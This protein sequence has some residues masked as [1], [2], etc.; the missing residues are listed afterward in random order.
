MA[1]SKRTSGNSS[2]FGGGL[3]SPDA[4]AFFDGEGRV[5][6]ANEAARSEG[7]PKPEIG[8]SPPS[9]AVPFW[10]DEDGRG[11]LLRAA[12]AYV[13]NMEVRFISHWDHKERV[14][15]VSVRRTPGGI[16]AAAR[17][18]TQKLS[19]HE[20]YKMLYEELASGS[21][22][23]LTTGFLNRERF[24][25]QLTKEIEKGSVALLLFDFD[26][27]KTLNDT[28]GSEAGDEY[29]S[30]VGE[31]IRKTFAAGE[32]FG[33]VGGDEI[34]IAIPGATLARATE[35]AD[36]LVSLI[37]DLSP[38]YHGH[39]LHLSASLGVALY[40]DHAPGP[41]ELFQAADFA[42][43][44][45]RRRG[46]ARFKIH[47]P[48]DPEKNRIHILRG[49]ANRVREALENKRFVPVFQ[50]VA[51]VLSGKIVSVE[52]LVRL[53][54]ADGT[55]TSPAEFLDAAER[56]GLVTL[57][58]RVVIAAAFDALAGFQR[59]NP[60]LEM[61][62][63]LS[64]HDFEDD[65]LVGGISRMARA[66]GIRPEKITFEIT[67]TAA[68]R[69]LG[70]V[71]NFTQALVAEGFRFA[72][73]DFGIGFSSF[74]YLRDLPVSSLKFDMSY[75]QG[76]PTKAENRV[77]VR[78]IAEICRGLGVKTVAEGVETLAV[79][80]ILKELGV[81]RVQGHLIGRPSA[82]LPVMRSGAFPRLKQPE[83][84]EG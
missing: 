3:E 5:L 45:A 47:D 12:E 33:R 36:R 77:F 2:G 67:E 29:L 63:N 58:D 13:Q 4:V 16:L 9:S 22:R 64:G 83:A 39:A 1:T 27:F 69:D 80:T 46:P 56:F 24:H 82:E 61:A 25:N 23:D 35:A 48:N 81:D 55:I 49:Q 28:H 41:S 38:E 14:F 68:L 79:L 60:E 42:M 59:K 10:V 17:D 18:V 30:H 34:A 32:I 74:K 15:W 54:E 11:R 66:K 37:A 84:S 52:T 53:K 20:L 6:L 8:G 57:I 40:P 76:L 21:D 72:L 51:D 75:V 26:D 73:D 43:N 7:T 62:I 50:P 44:Q 78:G 71:Q 31:T 65:A 70:R 19:E